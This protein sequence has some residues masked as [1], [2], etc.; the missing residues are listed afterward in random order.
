MNI[1]PILIEKCK[2]NDRKAQE[3]M[4]RKLFPYMMGICYRYTLSKDIS[5]EI[6]NTAMYKILT[7]INTYNPNYPFKVWISKITINTIID[8]IRKNKKNASITYVDEYF[9][10]TS[11]SEINNA[12]VKFN[13]NEILQLIE[14][15]N[16]TEKA[17]FNMFCI[18]NYSHEEIANMLGISEGTS[19]WYLN[20]ARKKLQ[21][22]IKKLYST[23]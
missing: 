20:Q 7:Q 9:D 12:L 2:N 14:Q 11:F 8:E 6:V 13:A 23:I 21:E 16:E 10:N 19:K 22:M 17:V 3:E 1:E 4:Y 18:D 15:L 5:K